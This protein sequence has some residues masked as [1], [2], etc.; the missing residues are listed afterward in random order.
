[1]KL[2]DFTP[3]QRQWAQKLLGRDNLE[4]LQHAKNGRPF[5]PAP[6]QVHYEY[7]WF[8]GGS[9]S[10]GGVQMSRIENGRQ[11]P[12]SFSGDVRDEI[13]RLR[14][15]GFTVREIRLGDFERPRKQQPESRKKRI[16]ADLASF[17]VGRR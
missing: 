7:W 10:R 17:K 5:R 2:D 4:K 9:Y 3:E 1:M 15:L 6:V 8:D 13:A 14:K 11:E 16:L 12:H